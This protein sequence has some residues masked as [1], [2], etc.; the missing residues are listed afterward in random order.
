MTETKTEIC[1]TTLNIKRSKPRYT[2]AGFPPQDPSVGAP[3]VSFLVSG[4]WSHDELKGQRWQLG[5]FGTTLRLV[6]SVSTS[7][8]KL[9]ANG[10][11]V[12]DIARNRAD[13]ECEEAGGK[14]LYPQNCLALDRRHGLNI[15][16]PATFVSMHRDGLEK[17][18]SAHNFFSQYEGALYGRRP[19]GEMMF[20]D[21]SYGRPVVDMVNPRGTAP[22][23]D[24]SFTAVW[25]D[26]LTWQQISKL[27]NDTGIDARGRISKW[28]E[29]LLVP[30]LRS[31]YGERWFSYVAYVQIGALLLAIIMAFHGMMR[32]VWSSFFQPRQKVGALTGGSA[33]EQFNTFTL[34][35]NDAE[36]A[37]D[38]SAWKSLRDL[39]AVRSRVFVFFLALIPFGIFSNINEMLSY[40]S[41]MEK[42]GELE[43]VAAVA[44]SVFVVLVCAWVVYLYLDSFPTDHRLL[45]RFQRNY[46]AL[47]SALIFFA[48]F[49]FDFLG[50]NLWTYR[51]YGDVG[52]KAKTRYSKI[53]DFLGEVRQHPK[54]MTKEHFLNP[55]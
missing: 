26:A 31:E 48:F 46:I 30:S 51:K 18:Y 11:T 28:S 8:V 22:F 36:I 55:C 2:L 52:Y 7:R 32:S 6:L 34:I 54:S 3:R 1:Y 23:L 39:H 33:P 25:K 15:M 27:Y 4:L 38:F 40:S 14:R 13:A 21:K 44:R 53:F 5:E 35:I 37:D 12:M 42:A 9:Y 10:T 41:G 43:A 29:P 19:R 20:P 24:I 47:G 45:S 50:D 16:N 17:A 49:C